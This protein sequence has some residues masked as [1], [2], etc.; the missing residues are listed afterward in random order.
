M[1]FLLYYSL[2]VFVD[3][4]EWDSCEMHSATRRS[5]RQR[6]VGLACPAALALLDS[7]S[8]PFAAR[9]LTVFRLCCERAGRDFNLQTAMMGIDV[10]LFSTCRVDVR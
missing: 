5:W 7:Q 6:V 10:F 4:G 8:S 1:Q 9:V 2:F 3:H